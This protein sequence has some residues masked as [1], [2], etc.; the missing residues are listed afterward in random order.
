MGRSRRQVVARGFTLV[1]ILVVIMLIAIVASA[2]GGFYSGPYKR[3]QV[4]KGARDV[5]LAAKYARAAAVE[6]QKQVKLVV[7][8]E[9]RKISVRVE[10][11]DEETSQ[12]SESEVKNQYWR[13]TALGG[14]AQ[15][16]V[17]T[18]DRSDVDAGVRVD[19]PGETTVAFRPDGSAENAVIQVGDGMKHYTIIVSG[20]TGIARVIE[21]TTQDVKSDTVDLDEKTI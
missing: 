18:V 15:F 11:W 21:G 12:A 7:E 2:A 17:V 10:N 1:E 6:Q 13:T 8:A 20:T 19:A 5:L 9:S 16:E 4:H 14:D 3:M